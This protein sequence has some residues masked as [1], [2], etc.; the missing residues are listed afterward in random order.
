[1]YDSR[2][3]LNRIK[4]KEIWLPSLNIFFP[5]HQNKGKDL[6]SI[7]QQFTI[8]LL[9]LAIYNINNINKNLSIK[10]MYFDHY[11]FI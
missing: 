9:F 3:N 1:M 8:Y 5:F 10:F 2:H 11:L 6:S 4:T 7:F